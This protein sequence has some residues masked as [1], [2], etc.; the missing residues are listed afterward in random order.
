MNLGNNIHKASQSTLNLGNNISKVSQSTLNL[1]N[2]IRVIV[3][4]S[5]LHMRES[6]KK[7]ETGDVWG[8]ANLDSLIQDHLHCWCWYIFNPLQMKFDREYAGVRPWPVAP[9]VP[10]SR[11]HK[12]ITRGG[13][14]YRSAGRIALMPNMDQRMNKF[15][16][17]SQNTRIGFN[18][19][20]SWTLN[21][22]SLIPFGQQTFNI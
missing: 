14:Y 15:G 21:H 1:E 20:C 22:Q 16:E 10:D 19:L 18:W 2:N 3:G 6:R 5:Y 12:Q 7:V 17:L 9:F 13:K 11:L 8:L 4:G